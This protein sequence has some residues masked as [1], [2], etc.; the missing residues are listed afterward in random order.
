LTGLDVR[1]PVLTGLALLLLGLVLIRTT[2]R[3]RQRG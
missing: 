1:I 3:T 2:S